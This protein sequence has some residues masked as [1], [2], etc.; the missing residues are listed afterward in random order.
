[1]NFSELD[2]YLDSIAPL[3][4]QEGWDNSGWQIKTGSENFSRIL[5][6][7]D[8]TDE[9]IEEAAAKKCELIVTHHPMY[10]SPL[11]AIRDDAIY[12]RYTINL[13]QA[14]ISVYSTH[15]PFDIAEGGNN[16]HLGKVL[17]IENIR[18]MPSDELRLARIGE[19]KEPVT[20]R[21]FAHHAS[22]ALN[23]DIGFFNLA[24]KPTDMVSR[25][26]WCTGAGAEY[27]PAAKSCGCDLFITGD[28]KY[29]AAL[30]AA[31]IDMNVLDLGHYA[32]E[33]IFVD[34]MSE[35]LLSIEGIEVFKSEAHKN[36]FAII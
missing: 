14:G 30:D 12:G 21:E 28:L 36:P 20:V 29:H 15:T 33:I 2:R 26:G 5:V 11:K 24:G 27:I 34:N 6:A 35:K 16:D 19:L 25:I 23:V 9:V 8:I 4:L 10:F 22:E 32:T 1:M 13:I 7:L 18:T 3:S 17:G 31:A